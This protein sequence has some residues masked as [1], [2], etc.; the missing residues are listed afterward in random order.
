MNTVLGTSLIALW[1][2]VLSG[3]GSVRGLGLDCPPSANSTRTQNAN[4]VPPDSKEGSIEQWKSC[5]RLLHSEGSYTVS[6]IQAMFESPR[7]IAQLLLNLK[8]AADRGL[9]VQPSFYDEAT[10]EKFFHGTKVTLAKPRAYQG[11]GTSAIEANTTSDIFPKL[12]IK[13]SSNC[14]ELKYE[15]NGGGS[16][17]EKVGAN[18]FL[19]IA[20]DS[21]PP[22]TLSDVRSTFGHE[23]QQNTGH[24]WDADGHIYNPFD[25]GS[26]TYQPVRQAGLEDSRIQ[27]LF[28]FKLKRVPVIE[29]S[30]A[31]VR[32]QMRD[33][34]RRILENR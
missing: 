18:G 3:C 29:N 6:E 22:I 33:M 19:E 10:L 30:D 23:D 17:T 32:I 20:A 24:G 31:V 8:I 21:D 13:V 25:E 4:V 2:A 26:L 7:N 34:Q 12:A 11:K 16:A 14:T 9:L 5:A 27:T 1:C 28:H 15:A